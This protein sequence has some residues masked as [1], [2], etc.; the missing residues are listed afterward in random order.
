MFKRFIIHYNDNIFRDIIMNYNQILTLE[1]GCGRVYNFK[2]SD[3][4]LDFLSL[5]FHFFKLGVQRSKPKVDNLIIFT[6]LQL[7]S[8]N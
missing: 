8:K 7:A 2:V 1:A 5:I 6:K 4:V 3:V